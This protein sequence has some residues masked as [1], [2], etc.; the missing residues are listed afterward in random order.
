LAEIAQTAA[1]KWSEP[2]PSDVRVALASQSAANTI[3]V[4]YG[5]GEGSQRFVIALDGRFVCK[6]PSC[7]TSGGGP[8]P[9]P[10]STTA[11]TQVPVMTMLLTVDPSTLSA[12]PS[13]AVRYA[14]VNLNSLGT[15][16]D[17]DA[18]LAR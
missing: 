14:D 4:N 7:A 8:N 16:Y 5:I 6:P 9:N 11:S 10:T 12:D 13:I 18:Y 1:L 3:G 15:V 17:L 2:A